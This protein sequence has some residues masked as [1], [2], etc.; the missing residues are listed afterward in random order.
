[1]R[2]HVTDYLS[3]HNISFSAKQTMLWE[4]LYELYRAP[5]SVLLYTLQPVYVR[6]LLLLDEHICYEAKHFVIWLICCWQFRS[7]TAFQKLF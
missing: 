7:V 1:M 3:D 5:L 4:A 2:Q 6:I